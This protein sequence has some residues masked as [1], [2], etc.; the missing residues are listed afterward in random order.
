MTRE[1]RRPH[2]QL[3]RE[4]ATDLPRRRRSHQIPCRKRFLEGENPRPFTSFRAIEIGLFAACKRP[5][6]AAQKPVSVCYRET[7]CANVF[8][9]GSKKSINEI[10]AVHRWKAFDALIAWTDK[11]SV[12]TY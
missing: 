6:R 3:T 11:F 7:N 9:R 2:D 4:R 8:P 10:P 12:T 5:K 1:E